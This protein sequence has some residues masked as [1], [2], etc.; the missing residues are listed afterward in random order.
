M[1]D[2]N[3]LEPLRGSL[4]SKFLKFTANS[5]LFTVLLKKF[6]DFGQNSMILR[7]NSKNSLFFSLFFLLVR[8]RENQL[9]HSPV[10]QF[11]DVEF[12]FG[13]A[14]DLVNPAELL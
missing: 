3:P 9:L 6:A 13:R 11:G 8:R 4:T 1:R 2:Q 5:L 7:S 12:V 14:G 10:Q